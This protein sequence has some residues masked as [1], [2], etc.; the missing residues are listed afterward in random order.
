[1]EP[2]KVLATLGLLERSFEHRTFL[3]LV[4]RNFVNI[5]GAADD[6]QKQDKIGCNRS[7]GLETVEVLRFQFFENW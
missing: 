6:F 7:F 5:I 4:L 3:K 2:V 1:M